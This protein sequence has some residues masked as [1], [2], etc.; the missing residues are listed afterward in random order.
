MPVSR[1]TVLTK[2]AAAVQIYSNEIVGD[3]FK[4]NQ[5]A[6]LTKDALFLLL[7]AINNNI[8][9]RTLLVFNTEP[10]ARDVF[11]LSGD[12]SSFLFFPPKKTNGGVPG[13]ENESYRY[14]Q[15]ALIGLSG[16]SDH[17]L[18]FTC[19][20]VSKKKNI[21]IEID[22]FLSVL[23]ISTGGE[24]DR[25]Y[26]IK[27]LSSWQYKRCD[28]VFEPGSYSVRGD[29]VDLF[30]FH[31]NSPL[32]ILFNYNLVSSLYYFD[33][34]T[35]K[36]TKGISKTSVRCFKNSTQNIEK[37]SIINV[38][39]WQ[40]I[41]HVKKSDETFS[42][43]LNHKPLTS[44]PLD[45]F[46]LDFS[47]LGR[48]TRMSLLDSAKL[49]YGHKRVYVFN[50]VRHFVGDCL[51]V[52]GNLSQGFYSDF[53]G[54]YCF[55]DRTVSL[56]GRWSP[57]KDKKRVLSVSDLSSISKGDYLV[58]AHHGVGR[59]A[60]L[61][62][63]GATGNEKECLTILYKNNGKVFVPLERMDI[64]HCYISSNKKPALNEIGAKKWSRDLEKVRGAVSLI[65][66]K[67]L[68][69]Y[70]SRKAGRGFSYS[71]KD[72]LITALE[73]SF[74][75]IETPD[76]QR[77]I[78]DVFN[79]LDKNN[80]MDRLICGDVGFGKTEVA[81]RAIMKAAVSGKQVMLL[82][83]TTILSDQ[84][85][86]TC[87]ERLSPLGLKTVLLSRFKTKKQQNKI[88]DILANRRA[89]LV[90]GTHRLLS[91]DVVIPE[92]SLLIIDEEHRFGV[93]HKEK[94]RHLKSG[95]DI[96]SLSAT[97]IPRTL[98]HSLV[99]VRDISKIRTPPKARRP[100]ITR[101]KYFDWGLIEV[102]IQ[103]ELGRG[104]QV[105]YVH[106]NI[107]SLE[108][109]TKKIR[110]LFPQAIVHKIH[111]QMNSKTLEKNILSFFAG[112]IDVLVCTTIIESGLDV[113]NANCIVINNSQKLGLSQLYQIRGRV[114]RGARQGSCLLLVPKKPLE[115]RAYHRLKTI[116]QHTSLGSGYDIALKDLEI[117]G[118]GSLFGHK[119]SGHISD[120][121]YEMYCQLLK[122]SV[123]DIFDR[124]QK[125]FFPT[126]SFSGS[127]LI[128][129]GYVK[130]PSVRLGFYEKL[131]RAESADQIKDV[132]NELIDRFGGLPAET[133]NLLKVASLRHLYK[134]T[135]VS[136]I[137]I[138]KKLISIKIEPPKKAV[139]EDNQIIQSIVLF[140]NGGISD[141]KFKKARGG[142]I[143]V[144]FYLSRQASGL[145]LSAAFAKLFSKKP[146]K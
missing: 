18:C 133:K 70:A 41:F 84:H 122:E 118:A 22:A 81:L 92:L 51:T 102:V 8:G 79:D 38:F 24:L 2:S 104:G 40:N 71:Q 23:D 135:L 65:S 119:Q 110:N 76:Q 105:Y 136:Q 49:K 15:E 97:P 134:N 142:K 96:L 125:D 44:I 80:P 91:E 99:G 37:E 87:I 1:E 7:L 121:G 120:V 101:V 90:I 106:N 74:P 10:A 42:I 36:K 28:F 132:K 98:Q 25:D 78:N 31:F 128:S 34:D 88:L 94:I 85:Y 123:D 6:V 55:L 72:D 58:H 67:L 117:R 21:P 4:G 86:I 48:A 127:A 16:E 56:H 126:I 138:N 46:P 19:D 54:V 35:Q 29:V 3:L 124:K 66:K 95:L 68:T 113:T 20:S 62:I 116:E 141:R 130:S 111:G 61:N 145:G 32:R 53:L 114:G 82:C 64:V 11:R 137:L 45:C 143:I 131:S 57:K 144:D 60:G 115:K 103:E 63:V 93:R 109:H 13:F 43:S 9:G 50:S 12:S 27:I 77:A 33:V 26:L 146:V 140:N 30:P 47:K 108:H 14:R 89:E 52:R 39:T 73:E 83:P 75:F 5:L 139:S 17:I 129:D 107:L 59:Y 69:L 100:I 112:K